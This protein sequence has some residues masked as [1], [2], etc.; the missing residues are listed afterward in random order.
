M[1][2]ASVRWST[3]AEIFSP[4]H[5]LVLSCAQVFIFWFSN[6]IILFFWP[7]YQIPFT[8]SFSDPL[9]LWFF[10]CSLVYL[11]PCLPLWVVFSI[12]INPTLFS[13]C[14]DFGVLHQHIL[15]TS[16][17]FWCSFWYTFKLGVSH[18]A[19][20]C[21]LQKL[22]NSAFFLGRMPL[23][24]IPLLTFCDFISCLISFAFLK[25]L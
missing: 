19:S 14:L 20:S 23:V 12:Y 6:L 22:E 9:V 10:W 2:E 5:S 7:D 3:K 13:Y 11:L 8:T 17:S 4:E 16:F 1:L 21:F 24:L 15:W 18:L 25:L